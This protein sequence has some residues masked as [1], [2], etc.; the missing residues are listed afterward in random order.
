M[1]PKEEADP[2]RIATGTRCSD[3]LDSLMCRD[4]TQA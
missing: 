3:V 4:R 2:N 1:K